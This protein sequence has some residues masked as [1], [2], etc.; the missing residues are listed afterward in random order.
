MTSGPFAIVKSLSKI[1]EYDEWTMSVE[2]IGSSVYWRIPSRSPVS[3]LERKSPLTSSAVGSA[4][5]CTTRST[6][7]PIGTGARID[8]PSTLPS[9]SGST[10]PIAR[11]APVEVGM[12][13]IAA[14][15]ARRRSLCGRSS[16]CWSFVY[17]WIVVM[18]PRSIPKRSCSTLASGATQFVVQDAFETIAC[19]S[20]S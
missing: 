14:A 6:I 10:T 18:K 3:A 5:S 2:T 15:R 19:R 9:S 4:P 20:G 12:R 13:L 16:T 8:M 7:E 1:D 17:A 11:A